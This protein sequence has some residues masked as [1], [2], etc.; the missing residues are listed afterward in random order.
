MSIEQKVLI[1]DDE[2]PARKRLSAMIES[3]PGF[4]VC[5]LAGSGG[6]AVEEAARSRPDIVLMDIRMPGKD[7][8]QAA[9]ELAATDSPP[10]VIFCTAYDEHALAAF[11]AS[12]VEYLLKPIKNDHLQQA[13]QKARRVTRAQLS[14]MYERSAAE[15]ETLLVR[16]RGAEELIGVNQIRALIADHKYVSAYLPEREILLDDSLKSLEERYPDQFL[17]VHRNALVATQYIEAL[18]NKDEQQLVRLHAVDIRPVVSRR[19]L[20]LVRRAMR[21]KTDK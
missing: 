16:V 20:P 9:T 21:N 3:I 2:P 15:N 19:L 10:A 1:V 6:E 4:S 18:E 7:G 12:A 8:L 14:S 17:R 13:L 11:R 5:A